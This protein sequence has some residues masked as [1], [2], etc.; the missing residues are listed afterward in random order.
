MAATM[1]NTLRPRRAGWLRDRSGGR[2][3]PGD[4]DGRLPLR[5]DGE[6]YGLRRGPE[7]ADAEYGEPVTLFFT[8]R[9]ERIA[10]NMETARFVPFWSE[11]QDSFQSYPPNA[12]SQI[13]QSVVVGEAACIGRLRQGASSPSSSASAAGA[14]ARR[15]SS[16][17][18]RPPGSDSSNSAPRACS[19]RRRQSDRRRNSAVACQRPPGSSKRRSRIPTECSPSDP[20]L[21]SLAASGNP[22]IW[23]PQT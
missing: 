18:S 21:T 7:P 8:D 14:S 2:G 13:A 12:G 3:H 4:R 5:A 23:F 17:T 22:V 16:I 1:P 20:P 11:G 6:E 10:G 15:T 19:R 9:R